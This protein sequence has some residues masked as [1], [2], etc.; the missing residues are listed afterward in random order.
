MT[1]RIDELDE[2]ILHLF[3]TEP[4]IGVLEAFRGL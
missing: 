2:R 4:R 1:S 3:S